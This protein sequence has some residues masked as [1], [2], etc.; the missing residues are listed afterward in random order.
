MF[1]YY[2]TLMF[3]SIRDGPAIWVNEKLERGQTNYSLTFNNKILTGG[4]KYCDDTYDIH[5]IEVFIL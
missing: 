1:I 4:E 2:F 5:N 3:Q